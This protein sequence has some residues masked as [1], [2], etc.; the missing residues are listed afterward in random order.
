MTDN[1]TYRSIL[2]VPPFSMRPCAIYLKQL[3]S[4]IRYVVPI[5]VKEREQACLCT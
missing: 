5:I 1:W 3:P 4:I 2:C